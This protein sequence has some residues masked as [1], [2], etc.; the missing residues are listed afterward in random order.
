MDCFRFELNDN[1][2]VA[3]VS[4]ATAPAVYGTLANK[5]ATA[6]IGLPRPL[7]GLYQLNQ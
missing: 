5:S 3:H 7:G 1:P 6:E 2:G 4:L